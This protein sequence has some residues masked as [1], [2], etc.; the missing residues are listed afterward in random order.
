MMSR[1]HYQD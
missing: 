1:N